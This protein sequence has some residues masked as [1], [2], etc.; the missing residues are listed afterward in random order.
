M[1]SG[2]EVRM[3][4]SDIESILSRL[5]KQAWAE[6]KRWP[7]HSEIEV[8]VKWILNPNGSMSPDVTATPKR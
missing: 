1:S 7:N 3:P 6:S 5:I 4:M 2:D 8:D